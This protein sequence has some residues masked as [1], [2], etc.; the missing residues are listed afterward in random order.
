LGKFG[1]HKA[2]GGFSFAAQNLEL[3]RQRL[4]E[5]AHQ[6]LQLEH[7]KPLVKIDTQV[8]LDRINLTLYQQIDS[9]QPWG[10]GNPF[11]VFWTP[12]VKVAEQ[13]TIGKNHLKLVLQEI[14]SPVQ[15]KA[16]AWR[17]QEYFPL[18]QYLDIA[19]K[20]K[21]NHWQGTTNIE[22]EIVGVRLPSS[23]N[24][25]AGLSSYGK[26]LAVNDD[27][28][29]ARSPSLDK[30]AVFNYEGRIYTCSLE[31]SINRLKIRNQNGKVLAV[32]KGDR[33]GLLGMNRDNS[34]EV[35]VTKPPYYQ[36]IKAALGAL[37]NR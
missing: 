28:N 17:W 25:D 31:V 20:L 5:F 22:L 14:D 26:A 30:Q 19:Y 24:D 6:C 18:P 2:A 3:I 12:N 10:I 33:V 9:L 16:I 29:Q 1:G 11:P 27:S 7:L 15:I 37:N 35:N 8:S 32:N 4:S 36:L 23:Q 13:K 21:E 34:Q